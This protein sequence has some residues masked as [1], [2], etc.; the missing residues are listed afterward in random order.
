MFSFDF[1]ILFHHA[2]V[3]ARNSQLTASGYEDIFYL[4]GCPTEQV[5]AS[6]TQYLLYFYSNL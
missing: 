4:T 5:A 2:Q 6:I 1:K 3:G